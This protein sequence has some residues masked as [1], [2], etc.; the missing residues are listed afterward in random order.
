[1]NILICGAQGQLGLELQDILAHGKADV[2][3]LPSVYKDAQV[4]GT[5]VAELDITDELAT[6]AFVQQGAFDLVINC[7]AMTNVDGCEEHEEMAFRVDATGAANLAKAAEAAGA[8]MVHISTDYVFSGDEHKEYVESDATNPQSAYGRSKRAGELAVLDA[9][10]SAYVVRTAWLFGAKGPNFVLTMMRL[11]RETGAITV[12]DDQFGN[13]TYAHDLAYEVLKI[14]ATEHYG[15]YHCT[16]K[17]ICSW[18]EFASCIVDAAGIA[19]TKTPCT[20]AEFPKPAKRPAYSPLRNAR[21]E[22]TIG[23]EMRDWRDALIAYL[24]TVQ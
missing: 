24:K 19:C 22:D 6:K 20:T 13:P 8:K 16:N 1:M 12:V 15:L 10:R 17:G 11:A 23:D 5:D 9:C 4:V 14:A 18:Y 3:S 21:L 7:A 2:G